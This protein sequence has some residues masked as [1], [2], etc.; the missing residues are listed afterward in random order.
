MATGIITSPS[1]WVNGTVVTPSFLQNVMDN[2][3]FPGGVTFTGLQIDGTGDV[4]AVVSAGCI[5]FPSRLISKNASPP[6]A[7]ANTGAGT[8]PSIS[9]FSGSTDMAGQIIVQTGSGP[10][11]NSI[12]A[13]VKLSTGGSAPSGRWAVITP[14][15]PAASAVAGIWTDTGADWVLRSGASAL[16]AAT[17]YIWNYIVVDRG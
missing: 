3:N 11:N 12:I 5:Q 4:N 13:T 10:T 16:T 1:S 9:F 2:I 17:T 7:V 15:N 14:G 6:T 8:S